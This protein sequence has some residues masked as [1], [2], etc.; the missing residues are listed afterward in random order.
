VL[1]YHCSPLYDRAAR[2]L[3]GKFS[4]TKMKT[5]NLVKPNLLPAGSHPGF[6][7]LKSQKDVFRCKLRPET[8]KKRPEFADYCGVLQL[9]GGKKALCRVWVHQDASL[10]LRLE[11]LK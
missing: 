9:N 7:K 2:K 10:G 8:N 1:N 4:K 6:G 3:F 11:M 5:I